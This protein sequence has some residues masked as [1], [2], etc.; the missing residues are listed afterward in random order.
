M[1]SG[2]TSMST[3]EVGGDGSD[4]HYRFY[5]GHVKSIV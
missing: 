3:A 5:Y 1:V 4:E 2:Y